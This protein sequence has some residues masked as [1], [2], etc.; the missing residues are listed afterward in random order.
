MLGLPLFLGMML[1]L[2][3]RR[4][5]RLQGYDYGLNGAYFV[6][7]NIKDRSPHFG[8]IRNEM[9]GLSFLGCWVWSCWYEIPFHFP[10]VFLDEFVVMPDHVH[11]IIFI[12]R[13]GTQD[14]GSLT[15]QYKNKFGPQSKNLS[16]IIRGFKIGVTKYARRHGLDFC[17]QARFHDHIIRNGTELNRIRQYIRDNPKNY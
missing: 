10:F 4:S 9:M 13:L 6:T 12:N 2:K 7:I 17:W 1:F 16:S 11:G 15:G 3:S 5:P 14:F 8:S